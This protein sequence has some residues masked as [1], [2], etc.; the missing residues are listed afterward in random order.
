MAGQTQDTNT[1]RRTGAIY[2][3][4]SAEEKYTIDVSTLM[5]NLERSHTERIRRHQAAVNTVEK[6]REAEAQ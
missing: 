5:D 3:L 2:E 4:L 1:A 6:L